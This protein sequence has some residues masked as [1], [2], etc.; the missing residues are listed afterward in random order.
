MMVTDPVCKMTFPPERAAATYEYKGTIYYFCTPNC[1]VK[2]AQDPELYLSSNAPAEPCCCCSEA[3]ED[4]DVKVEKRLHRLLTGFIIAAVITVLIMVIEHL[5]E[6]DRRGVDC[7]AWGLSSIAVFGPGGFLLLRGAKSLKNFKLN[8]FT[9][10]SMGIGSAY[11]YSVYALFF[12]GTLPASLLDDAGNAKL[13]FAPAAMIAAL[14]IL[15][16]YLEGRASRGAGRAI[17]SLMELVP[18]VAR[19]V[20]K[21]CGSVVEIPL[22]EVQLGDWLKIL[23][24]DKIPVDGFVVEGHGPVDESM[25][26]GEAVPVEKNV[27]SKLS[28]GTVNGEFVLTMQAEKVGS[29][30]LLAHIVELVKTARK[31]KL[32]VQ[33]LADKVSAFFVPAVLAVALIAFFCWGLI[34]RDWS[35]ALG[36]FIAVLLAACPCA[37]GL[38]APLAVTVGVGTGARNGILIKDPS[39]LESMKKVDTLMLDKTGTL[40]ENTLQVRCVCVDHNTDKKQ[41][42]RTLFAL[43]NN[44]R[45]PQ[46]KAVM[47]MKEFKLYADSLPEVEDFTSLPGQGV[48]GIVNDV[49]IVLG[50]KDF[51]LNEKVDVNGFFAQNNIDRSLLPVN[52]LTYLAALGRVWGVFAVSDII[53]PEAQQVINE[54]KQNAVDPVI[55]SGDNAEQV[56]LVADTLGIEEYYP[57]LKVQDKLE[58]VRARQAFGRCVAMV[59]DGVNDAAALAAADVSIAMGSGSDAALENAQI[60]LLAGN[61]G[62]L[63]KLFRLSAA[64]NGT[65]KLNLMLAFVYNIML[66]P[67]AA[68]AFYSLLNW[69]FTPVCSSIAMSG[70]CLLVVFNSLRLW[71][72]DLDKKQKKTAE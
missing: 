48:C 35:M 70:S 16:Q 15:G 53:R 7:L 72:L 2:F 8:M 1:K 64:V 50:S 43:E 71:H 52:S 46:A 31:T 36:A 33:K 3:F 28:A 23:P 29:D 4:D 20:K 62:K 34:A 12:A 6:L 30:T 56:K 51:M 14:V 37:L 49:R 61:I 44:S 45:H 38:A 39:A 47:A 60:T 25:L 17:K 55:I 58:K 5:P 24:H 63:G 13:H 67:L 59:G 9:L 41:F 18:P 26:T 27:G 42:Y 32:P 66:I 68:G 11:F 22:N 65:I 10:I 57:T 19:K 40:T 69:Q 54:F 21:C